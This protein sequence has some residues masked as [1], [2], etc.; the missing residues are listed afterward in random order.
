MSTNVPKIIT[1]RFEY[2][3]SFILER[4]EATGGYQA[5]RRA[6]TMTPAAVAE[7]VKTASLLGRGGAGFPAGV[8][9]GFC[10]PGVWPR[11]LVVN[12]DESEPG[13]YKDRILMERDPHQLIEGVLLACYAIGIIG[14][15][16]V[17]LIERAFGDDA[18]LPLREVLLGLLG[19]QQTRTHSYTCTVTWTFL[20]S[21]WRLVNFVC[22]GEFK[23]AP[24]SQLA[25]RPSELASLGLWWR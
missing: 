21:R 22:V 23:A 1:S 2:D 19:L 17:L 25:G 20:G 12:G 9:W 11:Y 6:L 13:T 5:L 4:Y 7:E 15:I 16:A 3:D 24:D 18:L 8:K 10:P 14:L